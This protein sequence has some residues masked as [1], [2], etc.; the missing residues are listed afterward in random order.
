MIGQT[1]AHYKI[2]EKIGSGGMG[3][4]YLA[5]DTKLGR[6]VALKV[7]PPE[8]AESEERRARFKREAKALAAL[9]H[10]NIVQVF[11]VEEAEGVHFITMQLVHGKTLTELL[12]KKGFLL[13]KFFEIGIP[14]SDAVAAAHQEGITHRDLKPDNVMVGDDGRIR[15]LDFGLA[16]PTGGFAVSSE[17]PT[18][19]KTDEGVIVGTVAYMS[20]EQAEAKPVDHRSDIF[21][22]GI[23]LYEMVTGQRP[24]RGES[25]TSVLSSILKDVP[26]L[27]S[28][29]AP[30]VPYELARIVRR[31]L[32]KEPSRRYQSAIDLRNDLEDLRDDIESGA[33][34]ARAE[35][36]VSGAWRR[37]LPWGV[38]AAAVAVALVFALG[39]REEGD[40]LR[41][42][43]RRFSIVPPSN[44]PLAIGSG[45]FIRGAAVLS[46]DASQLLYSAR[47]GD[48]NALYVRALDELIPRFLDG[49]EGANHPFFS[50]DGEW[51]GFQSG[52]VLKKVALG[53]GEPVILCEAPT[54]IGA[55]WARDGYIVFG[56]RSSGVWRVSAEGGKPE[57]L[58]DPRTEGGDLD[59]HF[60]QVLPGGRSIL[61][62][63][64]GRDGGF[65]IEVY[66]TD[67]GERKILLDDLAV[68]STVFPKG[69]PAAFTGR[70]VATGHI[71]YG[72][73]S[74]LFAAPFALDR[75][76]ITG[77][78]VRMVENVR[79]S[80]WSGQA[81]FSLASDGTLAYV[82]AA[83][84]EGRTLV[85]V[86][87]D[88]TEQ[89][90][91][92]SPRAFGD[93]Q[94]SPDGTRLAVTIREGDRQDVW[95]YDLD[96]E[97]R[98]RITFGGIH[99]S[100]IWTPDGSKITFT[101]FDS[102]ANLYWKRADGSGAAELLYESDV[103][104]WAGS[105][106]PDETVL[107]FTESF[108]F[109]ESDP[110]AISG[111]RLLRA[112]QDS[113]TEP[114]ADGPGWEDTPQFSPDGRW[115]AYVANA[116]VFVRPFPGLGVQRQISTDGGVD[117]VWAHNGRELYY[118]WQDRMIAVPIEMLPTLKAGRPEVLF[119]DRYATSEGVL[120][121]YDVAPDG[122][123]LMITQSEDELA[124]PPIHIVEG[125]REELKRRVPVN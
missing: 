104:Q 103:H 94:L 13:N 65:R 1:L 125:W 78:S 40:A 8:L 120:P 70:Y 27:A 64:H 63:R 89:A 116:E 14:L 62:T 114:F 17:G 85:W 39:G 76:E 92:V 9:D 36:P 67:T 25:A 2:L 102:S 117:P 48:G 37:L 26:P 59:A 12:P 22:I 98:Q 108:A 44:A 6:K 7:L 46:P 110:A 69:T 24:F 80:V 87:R 20:P 101:S 55:H 122:R 41:R 5:E 38:T 21:A 18:A 16:K 33:R 57:A 82:P 15:V 91:D 123:F 50:P 115:V 73:P 74:T 109:T 34:A 53:G 47:H 77:A 111:L 105:W 79:T 66:S 19:A 71:V 83:T 56:G 95:V 113:R 49:T 112:D 23:T 75:L 97:T 54:I 107:L 99:S 86:S 32:E 72:T 124:P 45:N 84:R 28:E 93:P 30:R 35:P 106:S 68:S 121:G 4:V 81:F 58:F 90:L 52:S 10:P 51:V 61:Y 31:C 96:N 42:P 119:E 29:I 100:P 60:P 43:V 3:D 11:S 88:G 118:R